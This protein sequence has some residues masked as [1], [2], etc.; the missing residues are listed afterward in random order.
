MPISLSVEGKTVRV[1][2]EGIV[3]NMVTLP[4]TEGLREVSG[5]VSE[6]CFCG[7]FSKSSFDVLILTPFPEHW[8]GQFEGGYREGFR[9]LV[10][11]A[12]SI[13]AVG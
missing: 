11:R 3:A 13:V 10:E 5:E 4:G 9:A 8:Q 2:G 1:E 12:K 6:F 7:F